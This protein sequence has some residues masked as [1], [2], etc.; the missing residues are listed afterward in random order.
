MTHKAL[1]YSKAKKHESPLKSFTTGY[2]LEDYLIGQLIGKGCNAA[3]QFGCTRKKLEPHPNVIQ[4]FRAFTADVPLLPGAFADYPD[5]LPA[6]INPAGIGH[7]RT[8]FLVMKNYPCTLWQSLQVSLP[9]NREAILL[10]LQLLEGVDHLNRQ[11]IAHRDLKSDNILL[12]HESVG[13]PCLVITDFGCCLA[14]QHLW[15]KL[16]F[17]SCCVDRGGNACLMA[18]EVASAVPG[19]GV[20]IDYSKADVWAVGA[21]AYEIFGLPNP[22][23]TPGPEVLESRTYQEKQ[24]PP[25]P[26]TVPP[27]ARLVVKLLL[28][29]NANKRPSARVAANL[30]HICQWGGNLQNVD[31]M[32]MQKIADWLLCRSAAALLHAGYNAGNMVEAELQR[33]FLINVDL[34]ELRMAM[35]FLSCEWPWLFCCS[36]KN[37]ASTVNLSLPGQTD[38]IEQRTVSSIYN[39]HEPSAVMFA[40]SIRGSMLNRGTFFGTLVLNNSARINQSCARPFALHTPNRGEQLLSKGFLFQLAPYRGLSGSRF[41]VPPSAEFVARPSGIASMF[42]LPIQD[43]PVGLDA[44]FVGV[45]IDTGTSNRPGARFGPRQIRAESSMMRVYN[46]STRAAPYQS[47]MVADIGDVNVNMYDLKDTCR[48]IR[49]A[50]QKIVAGGC[51]PL[52]LDTSDVVLGEK[53]GHGTPF[54]RCVEE[55]LLDCQR[56]AQIGLR[57]SAYSA[58]AYQWN[59]EQGFRVVQAEECWWKSLTPLMTAIRKQVGDG[60]VYLSFDIDALDPSYAPGTGTPEIAGLTPSQA[61]EIIRGCRGM[62]IVGCDLVEVSPPYDTTGRNEQ[63]DQS[64]AASFLCTGVM[65]S[66]SLKC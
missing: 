5:V 52:T 7:N 46:G 13:S 29:R 14:E 19:P 50:Y 32:K 47:L 45:P 1:F 66:A 58:D 6:R 8:L 33:N 28:R 25:L 59:R 39:L 41:N 2:K 21:I 34:G 9:D 40:R 26:S 20:V 35:A 38:F 30:L 60:P 53:I 37:T 62:N 11:G 57:G 18:P 42:K 55:G 63:K 27:E 24:L 22:F 64:K 65:V 15:L 54:R 48:R 17:N 43:S 56:V 10:I 44:A 51:I 23:Y 16:P 36:D 31:R 3:V 4:V 61:L 49:E 12:E